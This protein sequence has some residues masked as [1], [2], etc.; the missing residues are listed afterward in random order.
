[1]YNIHLELVMR[2]SFVNIK[3]TNSVD[4]V[5]AVNLLGIGGPVR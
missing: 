5:S 3:Q 1:M 2:K 4:F